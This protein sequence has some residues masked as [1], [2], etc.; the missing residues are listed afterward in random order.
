MQNEIF[1]SFYN[2]I[3]DY[4][5]N[6]KNFG[7]LKNNT[8]NISANNSI[9]GD[10]FNIF[11]IIHDKI[12]KEAK[13]FGEGCAIS[14]ASSSILT[15]I[16]LDKEFKYINLV[17]NYFFFITCGYT[18]RNLNYDTLDEKTI[19]KIS[20]FSNVK[21][22]PMRIKCATLTWNSLFFLFK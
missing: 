21:K 19:K 3:L 11:L 20:L 16:I 8:H 7:K 4:S 12:I 22:F 18:N 9:C 6:P 5:N 2:I 14:K 17:F 13:F 1:G 10:K 15:E